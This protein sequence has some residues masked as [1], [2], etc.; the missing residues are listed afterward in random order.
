MP[1]H[2]SEPL[3]NELCSLHSSDL[4][5]HL[6]VLLAPIIAMGEGRISHKRALEIAIPQIFQMLAHPSKTL[7]ALHDA[8]VHA[9]ADGSE[10]TCQQSK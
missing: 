1:D 2:N 7:K 5:D 6:K 3:K 4:P 10:Q 8:Y 9:I